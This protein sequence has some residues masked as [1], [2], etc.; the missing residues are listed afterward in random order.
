MREIV[1]AAGFAWPVQVGA[2]ALLVRR[3]ASTGA[4]FVKAWVVGIVARFLTLGAAAILAVRF[5]RDGG[6]TLL[7]G[8]AALLFVMLLL[9]SR[10]FR[11]AYVRS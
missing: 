3:G 6:T 8:L 2:F 9:E 5:F 7:L 10:Y 1:L 11:A 4:G